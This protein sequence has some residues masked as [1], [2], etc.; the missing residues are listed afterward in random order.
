MI[1]SDAVEQYETLLQ[2]FYF[3]FQKS[4]LILKLN[5]DLL[6]ENEE[7]RRSLEEYHSLTLEK[8]Y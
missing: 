7:L 1:S 5:K 4:E 2:E 3:K 8:G 6:D